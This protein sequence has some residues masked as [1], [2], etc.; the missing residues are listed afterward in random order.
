MAKS[1]KE[2]LL[3]AKS[4]VLVYT[5]G[6][7]DPSMKAGIRKIARRATASLPTMMAKSLRANG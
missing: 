3:M 2:D 6:K 1:T 5:S 4:M 7:M